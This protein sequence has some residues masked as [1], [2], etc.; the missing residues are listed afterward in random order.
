MYAD[1]LDGHKVKLQVAS[2]Q[3]LPQFI[4]K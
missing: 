3:I 2:E 1:T 4:H